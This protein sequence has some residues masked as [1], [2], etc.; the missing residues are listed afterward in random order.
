[1]Y[2]LG[3]ITLYGS[4]RTRLLGPVTPVT[5]LCMMQA[6]RADRG[7]AVQTEVQALFMY[8]ALRLHRKQVAAATAIVC[9]P[10]S[11]LARPTTIATDGAAGL[12]HMDIINEGT[13]L[14]RRALQTR[15]HKHAVRALCMLVSGLQRCKKA[16]VK[17]KPQKQQNADQAEGDLNVRGGCNSKDRAAGYFYL[18]ATH[19]LLG[20]SHNLAAIQASRHGHGAC[21]SGVAQRL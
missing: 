9:P 3:Y 15:L 21:L 16:S 11:Q 14:Y 2:M 19:A 8:R 7:G 6:M 13:V 1:M 18:G 20:K 12:E 4:G 17:Q 5:H 10:L